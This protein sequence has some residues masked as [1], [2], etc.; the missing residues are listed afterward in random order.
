[1]N[2]GTDCKVMLRIYRSHIRT[3]LDYGSSIY[4]V[5]RKSY[6]KKLQTIHCQGLRLSLRTLLYLTNAKL[7]Y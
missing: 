1:M 6:L 5:T 7:I 3:K 2:W 4:S